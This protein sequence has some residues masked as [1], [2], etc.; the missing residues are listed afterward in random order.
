MAYQDFLQA[1]ADSYRL[2]D[3]ETL[4]T[5][6][7]TRLSFQI[8]CRKRAAKA[9]DMLGRTLGM[10]F[11]GKRVLDIGCAYGAFSIE[12]ARRGAQVTGLDVNEKWLR[13][14]GLHAQGEADCTFLRCD[15]SAYAARRLLAASGPFDLMVLNDVFEHIYDTAALLDNMAHLLRPGGVVYYKVPNGLATRSVLSEGHKKVFA[16]SLLPPDYWQFFVKAPFQI[17]YRREAYFDALFAA[18]GLRRLRDL[19]EMPD[20]DIA[21]TRRLIRA[22][23]ATIAATLQDDDFARRPQPDLLRA[24][25]AAYAEEAAADLDGLDW[26]PLFRK[27]RATFWSGL[28]QR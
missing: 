16:L 23:L 1:L 8:H 22:D 9:V 4:L 2:P 21:G 11:A 26:V 14:A 17:Y 13:M 20:A 5:Q 18:K 10:D 27:Y 12:F 25:C 7:G 28:L 24:H 3:V 15:A 19:T 6:H